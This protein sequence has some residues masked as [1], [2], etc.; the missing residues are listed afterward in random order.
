MVFHVTLLAVHLAAALTHPRHSQRGTLAAVEPSTCPDGAATK[1]PP[2][3]EFDRDADLVQLLYTSGTTSRPSLP[4]QRGVQL[5]R[6]HR[7]R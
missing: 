3:Q 5:R 6:R 4:G 2:H 7:S 1:A